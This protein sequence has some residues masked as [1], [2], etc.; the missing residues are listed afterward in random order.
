MRDRSGGV[1]AEAE[2]GNGDER[3]L[4]SSGAALWLTAEVREVATARHRSGEEEIEVWGGR[5]L[6]VGSGVPFLKGGGGWRNRRGSVGV[7]RC[8]PRV[9]EAGHVRQVHAAGRTEGEG[10]G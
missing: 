1:D 3:A 9:E 5:I 8:G 10:R 7:R 2:A 6:I 4:M